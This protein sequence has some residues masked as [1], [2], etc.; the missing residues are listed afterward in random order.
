[1]KSCRRVIWW[2]YSVHIH[3]NGNTRLAETLSGIWG[4][5]IKENSEGS[6][7]NYDTL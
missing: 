6:E 7:F 2:K 4:R 3:V 5:R 1:M